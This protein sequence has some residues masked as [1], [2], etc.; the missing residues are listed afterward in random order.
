MAAPRLK[1]TA[2]RATVPFKLVVTFSDGSHGAFNAAEMIGERGEGTEPLRTNGEGAPPPRRPRASRLA[3][4]DA[5]IHRRLVAEGLV[6]RGHDVARVVS[7]A[8]G[9]QIEWTP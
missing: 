3:E 4:L 5:E 6:V 7:V 2:I 9:R 1:V 8:S